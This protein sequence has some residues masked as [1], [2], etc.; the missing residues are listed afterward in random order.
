MVG[1]T[2]IDWNPV[3]TTMPHKADGVHCGDFSEWK[4]FWSPLTLNILRLLGDPFYTQETV[5]GC[6]NGW[7]GVFD[8]HNIT[9][10]KIPL[11]GVVIFGIKESPFQRSSTVNRDLTEASGPMWGHL[12]MFL[13][14]YIVGS[15]LACGLSKSS[16]SFLSIL[17]LSQLF[18]ILYLYISFPHT[19]IQD[20]TFFLVETHLFFLAQFSSP[21]RSS[22]I[23]IFLLNIICPAP[24]FGVICKFDVHPVHTLI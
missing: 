21:T 23:M 13:S 11:L 22:W 18:F 8:F 1:F 5:P 17:P 14:L 4:H 24:G 3:L 20:F 6:W 19:I 7:G 9:T 2:D 16:W 12:E 15:H 10:A